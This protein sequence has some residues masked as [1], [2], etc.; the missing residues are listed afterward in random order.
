MAE[1][2]P[3]AVIDFLK[4]LQETEPDLKRSEVVGRIE[5]E[6]PAISSLLGK[7]GQ[8]SRGELLQKRQSL[9][10]GIAGTTFPLGG[11]GDPPPGLMRAEIEG[12][13]GVS[14]LTLPG[15][16]LLF[17]AAAAT[18]GT[19]LGSLLAETVDP[20]EKP[21]KTATQAAALAAV[22]EPAGELAVPVG[23]KILQRFRQ[24]Q[25]ARKLPDVDEIIDIFR[26]ES[27][28]ANDAV[29]VAQDAVD[30]AGPQ[31]RRAAAANLIRL[32]RAQTI[33]SRQ[34]DAA[35]EFAPQLSQLRQQLLDQ[36]GDLANLGQKITDED[37][38]K[39][40][41]QPEGTQFF[42]FGRV[43]DG[44]LMADPAAVREVADAFSADPTASVTAQRGLFRRGFEAA[45][46]VDN[47]VRSAMV[48][49]MSTAIRNF[50]TFVLRGVANTAVDALDGVFKTS[51]ALATGQPV[52]PVWKTFANDLIFT[53]RA[54]GAPGLKAVRKVT[55]GKFGR[56]TNKEL[57]DTI[58]EGDEK[59]IE[60]LFGRVAADVTDTQSRIIRTLLTFNRLQ[61][62]PARRIAFTSSI[63]K[64]LLDK[65]NISIF[66]ITSENK[67]LVTEDMIAKATDTALDMTFARDPSSKLGKLYVS[68]FNNIPIA[69]PLM[70]PFGRFTM[71]AIRHFT[72]INPLSFM[73]L[74]KPAERQALLA[75]DTKRISES[76]VGLG[77]AGAGYWMR[78]SDLAGEEWFNVGGADARPFMPVLVPY[79]FLGDLL[80]KAEKGT[81]KL[82]DLTAGDLL[83]GTVGANPRFG[84][85]V[86]A[87]NALA[88]EGQRVSGDLTKAEGLLDALKIMARS[89]APIGADIG[90]ELGRRALTPVQ[91]IS[92]VIASPGLPNAAEKIAKS[93]GLENELTDLFK[94]WREFQTAEAIVREGRA[95]DPFQDL[96]GQLQSRI[97]I[98]KTSLPPAQPQQPTQS[99]LLK[100]LTGLRILPDKSQGE[101]TLD[102]LGFRFRQK[103]PRS[104]FP[105]MDLLIN[106]QMQDLIDTRVTAL[107][108]SPGFQ[109]LTPTEQKFRLEIQLGLL[110]KAAIGRSVSRARRVPFLKD[111]AAKFLKARTPKT[112]RLLLEER[113]K[114]STSFGLDI[115][116]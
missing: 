90:G 87:I 93:L 44:K 23:R 45:K 15:L 17:R 53:V 11:S 35:T 21:F 114:Q 107:V 92:D 43:I 41:A 86:G 74:L 82:H 29:K 30:R 80:I 79:L 6:F 40:A 19:F 94:V 1:V 46:S 52:G 67:N 28:K 75:G 96:I 110:R 65:H 37:L 113:R 68:L 103:F 51:Y 64:Q 42:K 20:T 101:F 36:G 73:R 38:I 25:K 56:P 108:S 72:E 85:I 116:Q 5:A 61:E 47:I 71:A 8:P 66:D 83:R 50:E 99:P 63:D 62:F 91:Q 10:P 106:Q 26:A 27:L 88:R 34:F 49:N 7:I 111:I 104:K 98:A 54:L 95:T 55:G 9:V 3:Q 102:R 13:A 12:I 59:S 57:V 16:S 70:E 33:A 60:K 24:G 109:R 22:L 81:L 105:E 32:Q 2:E 112:K 58:L 97:P 77:L 100:Q 115:L 14:A 76:I 31:E 84:N 18:E 48:S 69:G 39:L 89:A 4:K 78:K